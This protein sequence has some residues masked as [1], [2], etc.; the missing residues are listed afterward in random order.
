[1]EE[2]HKKKIE[3]IMAGMECNKD[4]ECY[5]S[6]FKDIGKAKDRGLPSYVECLEETGKARACQFS[7]PFGYGVLCKC[8]LRI[9]IAQHL[10][11]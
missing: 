11:I 1:M 6:D 10:H 4:F 3:E 5:K 7:M 2:E 8:S 9:Y